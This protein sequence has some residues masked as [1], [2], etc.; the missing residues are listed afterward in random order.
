MTETPETATEVLATELRALYKHYINTLES[1]RD[2]IISRGGECDQVDAME[3]RD[4]VLKQVRDVLESTRLE[5]ALARGRDASDADIAEWIGRHGLDGMSKTDARCAFEDAQTFG[6]APSVA[7]HDAGD[8]ARGEPF[9]WYAPSIDDTCTAAKKR[10]RERD[11]FGSPELYSVALYTAQPAASQPS[12]PEPAD[13]YTAYA[14]WP[15]DIR[16][17]LSFHDLRR[18]SGWVPRPDPDGWRIDTSAGKPILVYRD[19]SVLEDEVARYVLSL[20]RA[21]K[22][23]AVEC[24]HCGAKDGAKCDELGCDYLNSS[25]SE[26]AAAGKLLTFDN[27]CDAIRRY[28]EQCIA[29]GLNSLPEAAADVDGRLES[30]GVS[31]HP[32]ERISI[33]W[34][35]LV[36]LRRLSR[37]VVDEAMVERAMNKWFDHEDALRGNCNSWATM[38]TE[39]EDHGAR[40]IRKMRAALTAALEGRSDGN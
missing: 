25:I 10:Q 32:D 27:V 11:G 37:P 40:L 31:A 3:K 15:E 5:R 28:G 29:L 8:I 33:K 24:P 35:E 1:A 18:M 21:D 30:N 13:I 7:N 2:Q 9:A 26:P 14:T 22:S 20:I 6:A 34:S 12:A 19:C 16:K 39:F 38:K 4:P 36:E 23:A 17:K